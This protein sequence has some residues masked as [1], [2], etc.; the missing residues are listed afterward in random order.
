MIQH[1]KSNQSGFTLV[2]LTLAMAFVSFILLFIVFAMIEIMG[3]YNK[4]IVV[5]EINQTARTIVEEMGRLSRSTDASAINTSAQAEGRLCFGSVSYAWNVRGNELDNKFTDNSLV[6]LVRVEDPAGSLCGLVSGS[7]PQIDRASAIDL[8][9]D[10]VWVQNLNAQV[11]GNQKLVDI[12]LKLSTAGD[13]RPTG[14]GPSGYICE[15]GKIGN[16]CAVAEFNTTVSTRNGG[17]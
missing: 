1:T 13:N 10:Q 8:I 15:G 6:G 12:D 9:S 7:Y 3:D 2:E 5:K 11:S 4:G 17:E 14:V 16:F